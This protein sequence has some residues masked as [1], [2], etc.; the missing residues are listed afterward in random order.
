MNLRSKLLVSAFLCAAMLVTTS[1]HAMEL[2]QFE[3]MADDDQ[4]RYI[5]DLL[6]GAMKV[7]RDGGKPEAAGQVS[8]LFLHDPSDD[9]QTSTDAVIDFGK[10]MVSAS[11]YDAKHV[12][13]DPNA[14]RLQV[15][16]VMRVTLKDLGIEVPDSFMTVAGTFK[17][18]LPPKGKRG[19][20]DTG[21]GTTS[22]PEMFL[23]LQFLQIALSKRALSEVDVAAGPD[24]DCTSTAGECNAACGR[25]SI[26]DAD[27]EGVVEQSDFASQCQRSCSAGTDSCKVQDS[28]NSCYTFVYHC[29]DTCPWTVTD[30]YNDFSVEHSNAFQQCSAACITGYTDC[31]KISAK[32]APRK[33][34]AT[35]DACQEAQGACYSGCMRSAFSDAEGPTIEFTDF[36]DKCAEACFNGVA[37]CRSAAAQKCEEFTQ[38]CAATCPQVVTDGDGSEVENANGTSRC[39]LACKEGQAFCTSILQ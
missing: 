13:E 3:L 33:R 23:T 14:R 26:Y 18:A 32:L 39:E 36:P 35:F 20:N 34:T 17:P 29:I 1:A 8:K 5:G 11:A 6:W 27:R 22:Q 7:L 31:Q 4:Y 21:F 19:D 15:E 9:D 30:T 28:R 24:A 25:L 16:D 2:Q 10:E 37:P 12:S 38:K